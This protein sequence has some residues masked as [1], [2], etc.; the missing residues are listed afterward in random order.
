M[1]TVTI[2][3]RSPVYW[4][5]TI[6]EALQLEACW[7]DDM[8]RTQ[9]RAALTPTPGGVTPQGTTSLEL[10][11]GPE[12]TRYEGTVRLRLVSRGLGLELTGRC[13]VIALPL[14]RSDFDAFLEQHAAS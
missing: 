4:P 6:G 8:G 3:N 12:P 7:I 1:V 2:Q 10:R 11:L 9:S 13:N 14:A 5:D